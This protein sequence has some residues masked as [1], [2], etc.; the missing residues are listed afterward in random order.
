ME[1][2][3]SSLITPNESTEAIWLCII[4]CFFYI[5]FYVIKRQFKLTI[6]MAFAF[7]GVVMIWGLAT[8]IVVAI[9]L[10]PFVLEGYSI[11]TQSMSP[12]IEA[13]D[14]IFVNKILAPTRLDFIAFYPTDEHEEAFCKRVIGMPGERLRF[15]N[16]NVYINDKMIQ[17]P[18]H[19]QGRLTFDY[20]GAFRMLYENGQTIQLQDEYF[21]IGD[22][23][24]KSND[25]RFTGPIKKANLIGVVDLRYWPVK[26]LKIFR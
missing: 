14:H 25:S 18:S 23:V 24:E 10:K 2:V 13:G 26:R 19:L 11:P 20:P 12:T 15:E 7:L 6:K 3:L 9:T 22:N 4:P 1:H 17:L 8:A 5:Y 21:A 16:G